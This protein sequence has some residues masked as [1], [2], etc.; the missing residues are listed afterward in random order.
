MTR[1]STSALALLGCAVL[2]LAA[3]PAAADAVEE[4]KAYVEK[5]SKPNPPWDGPTSGPKA[6]EG[7]TLVYVSTDQRNG[8]ARG[9]GEGVEEAAGKLGWTVRVLDGQGSVSARSSALAQA[10]ASKPDAI[11]LGAIDATEQSSA[12]EEAAKQGITV[13][14]WHAYAKAGPHDSMPIFTNITTD[15][16]EVAKAAAS[17]AVAE[18]NGTAGAVIFTDSVYEIAVAKAN[19]MADII[20]ACSGCKMLELVD[21]PLAD[22]STRMPP[23]TTALLQRYGDQW[24]YALSINDLTFDF[25]APSLA[26]AGIAGDGNPRNISAGDGSGAAFQRIQQEEHQIGTVAEP[27]R[28]H[29]WQIVDEANRAFAGEKDSGYV[30]PAH[31]FLP[32]NVDKDGGPKGIYDPENGYTD[33][34]LKIWGVAAG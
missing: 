11:I 12:V 18:S 33:A 1:M 24:T 3:G 5:V 8:G 34:Y 7:K 2:A 32:T 19:A 23:L 26:A 6:A 27:L 29:G 22:A 31:L 20:K 30:A 13:I 21:T 9:V 4:A 28:L 15:P 14:G 17:Y 10:I 25:M 16:M